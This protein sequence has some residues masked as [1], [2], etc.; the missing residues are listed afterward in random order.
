[1]KLWLNLGDGYD[2]GARFATSLGAIP[3]VDGEVGKIDAALRLAP[4]RHQRDCESVAQPITSTFPPKEA[5]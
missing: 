3:S 4:Q 1:M 5:S 2:Q